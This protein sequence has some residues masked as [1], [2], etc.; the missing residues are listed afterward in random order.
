MARIKSDSPLVPDSGTLDNIIYYNVNGVR[1]SRSK[2]A[3]YSPK[4]LKS[5]LRQRQMAIF[6]MVQAHLGLHRKTLNL[7]FDRVGMRLGTNIYS[8]L[9]GTHL[10]AALEPLVAEKIKKGHLP[11]SRIEEAITQYAA[12]HPG[13]ICISQRSGCLPV[14]LNGPWPDT[15]VL[16]D[17]A[18]A[19]LQVVPCSE[20][21][22]E[23]RVDLTSTARK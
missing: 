16:Q 9:N 12:A 1:Y 5:P 20:V 18:G 23:L 11:V 21:T 4:T 6:A 22:A 2:P 19:T 8:S 10:T 7:T 14:Y 3:Q 13:A 15:I 17:A